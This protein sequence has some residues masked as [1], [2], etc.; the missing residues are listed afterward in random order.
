MSGN[1]GYVV[2]V[3]IY[4]PD[5]DLAAKY[6]VARVQRMAHTPGVLFK[7]VGQLWADIYDVSEAE[8]DESIEDLTMVG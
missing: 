2:E 8:R 7:I 4:A 1:Q 3:R 5:Q 6:R